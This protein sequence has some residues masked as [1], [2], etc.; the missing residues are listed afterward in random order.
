MGACRQISCEHLFWI[1]YALRPDILHA[2]YGGHQKKQFWELVKK[3]NLFFCYFVVL[4]K[5]NIKA[6]WR[7]ISLSYLPLCIVLSPKIRQSYTRT[8]WKYVNIEIRLSVFHLLSENIKLHKDSVASDHLLYHSK[9]WIEKPLWNLECSKRTFSIFWH[10][11]HRKWGNENDNTWLLKKHSKHPN[12][13]I[14]L[15]SKTFFYHNSNLK[16]S[17]NH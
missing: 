15:K 4:S 2:K 11:E 1:C 9:P 5:K 8:N 3:K 12:L 16:N 6:F 14:S 13:I 10:F 17:L 7:K